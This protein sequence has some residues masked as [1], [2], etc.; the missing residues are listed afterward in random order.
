MITKAYIHE[1]GS[2]KIEPEHL[3][4]KSTLESRGVKCE[5]FTIKRLL[6]NQLIL[7]EETLVVGDHIVMS[8][9][10]KRLGISWVNDSYPESLKKYLERSVWESSVGKLLTGS[11]GDHLI[12]IFIK[13]KSKAKLFTGFVINS[14]NDLYILNGLSKDTGLYCSSVVEWLSEFRVFV[15]RS[16]IV[17]IKNYDGDAGLELDMEVVRNAIHDFEN[18]TQRTDAYGIDFGILANGKTALVEWNDGFALGSYGLD[19]E[20]YTDL[21]MTRWLEI[22]KSRTH[23]P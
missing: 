11:N 6:R 16:E 20:L 8:N 14:T 3:D 15:N 18:S 5:I 19:R 23:N 13:P 9:V 1:Y 22:I 2:N 12:N 4:V 17:G 10:F 21:I 7:D